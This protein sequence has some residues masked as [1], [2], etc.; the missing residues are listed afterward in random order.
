MEFSL[1]QRPSIH[2]KNRPRVSPK[3]SCSQDVQSGIDPR[4]NIGV[5][6]KKVSLNTVILQ[7]QIYPCTQEFRPKM[8]IGL[9][10]TVIFK[11][12]IWQSYDE[13]NTC[14]KIWT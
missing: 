12:Q 3:K 8:Y 9:A 7:V 4:T 10:K 11:T 5:F 14:L 2:L 1:L 13:A 6:R